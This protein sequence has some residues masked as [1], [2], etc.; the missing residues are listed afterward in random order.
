MAILTATLIA[1]FGGIL[2]TLIWLFFWLSED[3]HEPEPKRIIFY[4]FLA[5]MIMVIPV[6]IAERLSA[7]YT[8]GLG[9]F[10]TWAVIEEL[11]KF[12]AAYFVAFR[13]RFFDEPLDAVIY[14]ITAALGFSALENALFLWTPLYQQNMFYS[15]ATGELRF[16]GATPLHTLASAVTGVALAMSFYSRTAVKRFVLLVGV[17]LSIFLHTLFNFSI[18]KAGSMTLWVFVCVWLGVIAVLLMVEGVKIPER[19]R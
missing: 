17:I 18:L 16:I 6:L 12:C 5:G 8:T 14:M 15:F 2:P 3:R 9:L 11:A 1:L 7:Q 4:T 13:T 10:I 19:D